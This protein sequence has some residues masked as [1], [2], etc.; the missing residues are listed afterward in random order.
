MKVTSYPNL[1][2]YN[3]ASAQYRTASYP[4]LR[5]YQAMRSNHNIMTN[6]NHVVYL[7]TTL[8]PSATKTGTVN[9]GIRTDLNVV[10]NLDNP[11]LRYLLVTLRTRIITKSVT[12]QDNTGVQYNAIPDKTTLANNDMRIKQALAAHDHVLA[13]YNASKQDSPAA[14]LDAIANHDILT[15]VNPFAY[16]SR[17]GNQCRL[18]DPRTI[19]HWRR[20]EQA[21]NVAK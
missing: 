3:H 13:Q 14:N 6:L 5:N 12:P 15:N 2:R 8:N 7:R 10:V 18:G 9:T 11:Y 4:S 16:L 20:R 21:H 19:C 17:R 1:T